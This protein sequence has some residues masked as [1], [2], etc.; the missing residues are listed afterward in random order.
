MYP[1]IPLWKMPS[2][3][4]L[5]PSHPPILSYALK[6]YSQGH[7]IHVDWWSS[8][9]GGCSR[10]RKGTTLPFFHQWAPAEQK[11]GV[12]SSPLPSL[13]HRPSTHM[14]VTP[15]RSCNLKNQR[16]HSQKWLLGKDWQSL[17]RFQPIFVFLC[18]ISLLYRDNGLKAI[19]NLMHKKGKFDYILLETTGLADPG[20]YN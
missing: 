12:I 3:Y 19:E 5:L 4:S 2:W 16:S 17:C 6:S 15:C 14:A 11:K 20:T 9:L 8:K 18:H 10:E 13:H 1:L 7:G